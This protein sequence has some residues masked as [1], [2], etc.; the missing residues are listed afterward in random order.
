MLKKILAVAAVTA[1]TTLSLTGTALAHSGD[2]IITSGKG[3]ILGGNQLVDANVPVN[4]CGNAIAIL[5]F[6]NAGCWYSGAAVLN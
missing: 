3:S 4:V 5:G 6:A 2:D 1:A